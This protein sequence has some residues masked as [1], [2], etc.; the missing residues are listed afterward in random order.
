VGGTVVIIVLLVL[1]VPVSIIM[2]GLVVSGLLG[3]VLKRDV[4]LSH[5]GS[6]L[7]ALSQKDLSAPT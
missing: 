7:L 3:S 4:D 2:S 6:E 5:E 1:V